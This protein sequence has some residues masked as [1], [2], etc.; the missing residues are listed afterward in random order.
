MIV[1]VYLVK[2]LVFRTSCIYLI[3]YYFTQQFSILHFFEVLSKSNKKNFKLKKK[4]NN[5]QRAYQNF[6]AFHQLQ[7]YYKSG[8]LD[9]FIISFVV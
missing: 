6:L 2:F 9:K 7:Q 3:A 1:H 8:F 5:Y 4:K